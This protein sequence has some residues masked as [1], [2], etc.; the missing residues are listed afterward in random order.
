MIIEYSYYY[1]DKRNSK[2]EFN[3]YGYYTD[4]PDIIKNTSANKIELIHDERCLKNNICKGYILKKNDS[5]KFAVFDVYFNFENII[6]FIYI[7]YGKEER[8]YPTTIYLSCIIGL[9]LSIPNFLFFIIRCLRCKKP[10]KFHIFVNILF[11]LALSNILSKFFYLGGNSSFILG[12]ILAAFW[13]LLFLIQLY[14]YCCAKKEKTIFSGIDEIYE[15]FRLH[16]LKEKI[17]Q[18][19]KLY[20]EIKMTITAYHEESREQWAET[21]EHQEPYFIEIYNGAFNHE[22]KMFEPKIIEKSGYTNKNIYF[23][24][25]ERVDKGGGK[26]K[27]N[28]MQ[29]PN[30]ECIKTVEK[31]FV[32]PF[33]RHLTFKYGSWQDNT[34]TDLI[35]KQAKKTYL[36]LNFEYEINFD[37]GALKKF[38]KMRSETEKV[39]KCYDTNIKYEEFIKCP[40]FEHNALCQRKGVNK[41]KNVTLII[42]WYI[43]LIL[44]YSSIYD[45]YI[46]I[47]YTYFNIKIK[48]IVSDGNKLRAGYNKEEKDLDLN[49]EKSED[50]NS[51]N[52]I[53]LKTQSLLD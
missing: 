26:M 38:K 51:F 40:G 13:A 19:R 27:G 18:R 22:K 42:F 28:P 11:H 46:K 10:S 5:L 43:F 29:N 16:S 52:T 9:I 44:G 49:L 53:E 3:A 17:D 25:W 41:C 4:N 24:K 50:K 12:I 20:P 34:N 35:L 14:S 15:R 45:Y 7:K 1:D 23:S 30:N 8:Y 6:N 32:E 36:N 2:N 39:A 33:N 21:T 37:E 47:E 48:K 31:K